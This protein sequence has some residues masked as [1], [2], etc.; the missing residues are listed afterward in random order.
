M[1]ESSAALETFIGEV[2]DL[3]RNRR[4]Y[5]NVA[6]VLNQHQSGLN[7]HVDGAG[8]KAFAHLMFNSPGMRGDSTGFDDRFSYLSRLFSDEAVTNAAEI[9]RD[10]LELEEELPTLLRARL[11]DFLVFI[12]RDRTDVWKRVDEAI[13]PLLESVEHMAVWDSYSSAFE[14]H[15]N[16]AMNLATQFGGERSNRVWATLES[17]AAEF[18]DTAM[19]D[20][21]IHTTVRSVIEFGCRTRDPVTARKVL[22]TLIP[23]VQATIEW[24][25]EQGSTALADGAY[26]CLMMAYEYL[27]QN[28][29]ALETGVDKIETIIQRGRSRDRGFDRFVQFSMGLDAAKKLKSKYPDEARI[30]KLHRQLKRD[31]KRAADE[32]REDGHRLQASRKIPPWYWRNRYRLVARVDDPVE[33]VYALATLAWF[34]PIDDAWSVEDY[35]PKM[36]LAERIAGGAFRIDADGQPAG[37]LRTDE[38][39]LQGRYDRN[40][41]TLLRNYV[42][43]STT[44]IA[45]RLREDGALKT[46]SVVEAFRRQELV[47]PNREELVQR[48]IR[49]LLS[50]DFEIAL[51]LLV[52][53]FEASLRKLYARATDKDLR[54][55]QGRFQVASLSEMLRDDEFRVH[56]GLKRCWAVVFSGG[57]GLAL[58]RDVDTGLNLRNRV[59]HGLI[60]AEGCNA[61]NSF[62]VFHCLLQLL[63]VDP[64]QPWKPPEEVPAEELPFEFTDHIPGER[65]SDT[66]RIVADDDKETLFRWSRYDHETGE[67]RRVELD[68]VAASEGNEEF[69]ADLAS[70]VRHQLWREDREDLWEQIWPRLAELGVEQELVDRE[71][72]GKKTDAYIPGV[73]W[74]GRASEFDEQ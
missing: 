65:F 7:D 24:A 27:G 44:H 68:E 54:E 39:K 61:A 2:V 53:Q 49:A 74:C 37:V 66:I 3:P 48:G 29:D 23:G 59:A 70:D 22:E 36:S 32:G 45:T 51:H 19:A 9:G 33:R 10:L 17:V 71:F 52:L 57:G 58:K 34:P 21:R 31:I 6:D 5:R 30:E 40:L 38:E 4:F 12:E 62:L 42:R 72:Q 26:D 41:K 56:P 64:D 15:L 69:L 16:R 28:E 67:T 50:D 18:A 11:L 46:E 55:K 13:P 20:N 47:E 14:D 1:S 73:G 43:L 8:L 35:A 60:G 25:C 63:V